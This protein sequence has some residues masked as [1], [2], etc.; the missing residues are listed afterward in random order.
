VIIHGYT[1]LDKDRKTK[2]YTRSQCRKTLPKEVKFS[3]QD[4]EI[5]RI[6]HDKKLTLNVWNKNNGSY[7]QLS[8]EFEKN[9]IPSLRFHEIYETTDKGYCLI[10][11][12]K[13]IIT[14]SKQ[15][16]LEKL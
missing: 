14:L 8:Y 1:E 13:G 10:K 5:E 16:Q 4:A 3:I 15:E 2:T 11:T 6:K 7:E 9:V 12:K